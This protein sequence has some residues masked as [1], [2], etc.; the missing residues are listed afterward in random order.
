MATKIELPKYPSVGRGTSLQLATQRDRY[1]AAI[2]DL[3]ATLARADD[4]FAA[5]LADRDQRQSTRDRVKA[6]AKT[7]RDTARRK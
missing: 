3:R 7:N 5:A 1:R 6:M 4:A 2:A